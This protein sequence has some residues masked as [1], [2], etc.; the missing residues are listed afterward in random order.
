MRSFQQIVAL[1]GLSLLAGCTTPPAAQ[2]QATNTVALISQY[3]IELAN[4]RRVQQ[5]R[6]DSAN[7]S[8][9]QNEAIVATNDAQNDMRLEAQTAAGTKL[10][11]MYTKIRSLSD[12]LV[13][14]QAYVTEQGA[15]VDSELTALMKPLDDP[16]KKIRAAQLAVGAM[17]TQLSQETRNKELKSFFEALKANIEANKDKIDKAQAP[18]AAPK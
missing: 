5:I 14:N 15:R 4:F 17:G 7:A 3:Q 12:S 11:K 1:T 16:T 6:A 9:R 10:P 13:K 2:N 8:I 18:A